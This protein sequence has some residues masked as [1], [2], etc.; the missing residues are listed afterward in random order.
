MGTA[1]GEPQAPTPNQK[2]PL[3]L[4]LMREKHIPSSKKKSGCHFSDFPNILEGRLPT[5]NNSDRAENLT[6][7]VSDKSAKNI[8]LAQSKN[9]G[10]TFRILPMF[11]SKKSEKSKNRIFCNFVLFRKGV[12]HFEA[13]RL[14]F[15]K[16]QFFFF[17]FFLRISRRDLRN[18]KIGVTRHGESDFR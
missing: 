4:K 2:E 1:G 8:F 17:Y 14:T 5:Q 9:P 16:Q 10:V 18:N 11:Q 7:S 15:F 3:S 6:R 13:K 12:S